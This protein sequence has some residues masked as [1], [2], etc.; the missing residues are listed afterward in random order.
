[1]SSQ[2]EHAVIDG[3]GGAVEFLIRRMQRNQ[4]FPALSETIRTLNRLSAASDKSTEHLADVIVRDYALT[5]KI[6]K[7]VNSAFYAGF[8]GK[9][10][11]ISRAIVVLGLEPIRSLAAS[12]LLFEQFSTNNRADKVKAL[13]GKSMFGALLARETAG[14]AGLQN[15][16]EAFLASMFH[17]LG[18]LLVAY[19]LPDEDAAIEREVTVAEVAAAQAQLRVLGVTFEQLGIAIGKHWNFP[20]AI[21]YSMKRLPR[22]KPRSPDSIEEHL[23]QIAAFA[24]AVTERLAAGGALDDAPSRALLRRFADAV[25]F[26][27]DRLEEVVANTRSEYRVLAEVLAT[28]SAAPVA[29]RALAGS[30]AAAEEVKGAGE[31]LAEL[32]LPDEEAGTEPACVEPEPILLDGLQEATAILATGAELHEVAQVMLET[33]FRA[34]G[35]RRVAL[36]LRDANRRQYVG[37]VGFGENIDR[38]L[39]TLRFGEK[40]EPDVFHVAL[41]KKTDVHI[42]DLAIAST[43]HGIPAWYSRVSPTGS[44]LFLPLVVRDRPVGCIIAEH[45][46]PRGLR[47]D[48]GTLRLVR[49]LRNQLALGVQLRS[50]GSG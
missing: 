20:H 14:D 50:K 7:V 18:E 32:A 16:E 27:D 29:L 37:R 15:R 25:A 4:D 22:D 41:A 45:A 11:T 33:L 30:R 49:A 35:L 28:S 10:G 43:G 40:Y 6:L 38:F 5:N 1:M 3:A 9:V 23:R 24:N 21:T 13:I 17:N 44:L 8:A 12:L 2:S 26:D 34:F 39:S 19:Y 46:A 42:E 31:E 36:C 48:S 47:I